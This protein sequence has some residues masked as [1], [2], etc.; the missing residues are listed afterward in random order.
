MFIT[1]PV[2]FPI[3]GLNET[4]LGI[5]LVAYTQQSV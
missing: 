2:F 4:N 5:K 3:V 1:T